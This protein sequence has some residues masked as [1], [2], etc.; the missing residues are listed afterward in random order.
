MLVSVQGQMV[1]ALT[2]AKE[3]KMRL[4]DT[5]KGW[6]YQSGQESAPPSPLGNA[7]I[8]HFGEISTKEGDTQMASL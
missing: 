5:R 3:S 1:S 4:K 8:Y 6:R 7:S 2:G